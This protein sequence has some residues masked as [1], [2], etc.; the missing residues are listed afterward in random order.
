M[1][2]KTFVKINRITN[3]TDARYCAGMYANV[4][5]FSLEADSPNFITPSQFGEITG[6]ISGIEFA[7]EF[8]NASSNEILATLENYPG[9]SWVESERLESLLGLK[10]EALNLIYKLPIENLDGHDEIADKTKNQPLTFHLTSKEET[11]SADHFKIIQSLSSL[12]K[13]ILGFG[14]LAENVTELSENANISGLALDS[15]DE[16]KPGLR[17][18]DL[19]AD[20]LEALEIED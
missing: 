7:A 12:G 13:V 10:E 3:L 19:L 1:S 17:D 8:K 11:L 20:I 4:I 15:G 9:I 2:L 16:I 5:G 6:W 18:F 14:I